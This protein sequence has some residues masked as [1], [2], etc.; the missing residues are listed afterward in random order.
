MHLRTHIKRSAYH[1]SVTLMQVAKAMLEIPGVADAAAVMGTAA[2]REILDGAGLLTPEA[3]AAAADDLV[4]VAAASG[5]AEAGAAIA[6][7]VELLARGAG[8]G[9]P[10]AADSR[11]FLSLASAHAA[12]PG[13]NLAVISVAGRY[14]AAEARAALERGLHVLLFSDNV[15]LDDEIA[16][17]RLARRRGLLCMGPDAGTAFVNGAGLGFANAVPRGPVGIVAAS[18]TGLQGVAC[19]LARLGTGLS[20]GIGAGGRDLSEAVGGEMMVAGLEALQADPETRVVV[21]VS[22][23]PSPSAARR[24]L[25]QLGR[26]PKPAVVCFLGDGGA[27]ALPDHAVAAHTLAEAAYLAARLAG[28]NVQPPG[29]DQPDRDGPLPRGRRPARGARG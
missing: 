17:K 25:D 8:R 15:P 22:K 21:L 28:A 10:A 9:G 23:P 20:Q 2:N 6:H 7:G 4:L 11:R 27:P 26:N 12:T 14:A 19:G 5:D 16:L 29:D 13:A 3:A 24:V 18:G 1:D